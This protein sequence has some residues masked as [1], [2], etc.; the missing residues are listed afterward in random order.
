MQRLESIAETRALEAAQLASF[1]GVAL[2]S[3]KDR[4]AEMLGMVGQTREIFATYTKH[5]ISHI[6]AMLDHLD[7]LIPGQTKVAMTAVDWLLITLAVYFHDLGMMVA[8]REFDE[9]NTNQAYQ[10]FR[11]SLSSDPKSTDYLARA[12]RMSPVEQ[13][14]FFFQEFIRATH[15]T[16]IKEWITGRV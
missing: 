1:R 4:V 13:E 10:S 12:R 7:W 5:D 9:R 16:R 14:R 15:A 2:G 3:I 11:E 6:N 8:A